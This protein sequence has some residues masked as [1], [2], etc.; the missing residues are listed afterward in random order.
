MSPEKS[1]SLFTLFPLGEGATDEA[2]TWVQYK[3]YSHDMQDNE[4]E[5]LKNSNPELFLY[6]QKLGFLRGI[7]QFDNDPKTQRAYWNG[8]FYVLQALRVQYDYLFKE[9]PAPS[10]DSMKT[11]FFNNLDFE[12]NHGAVISFAPDILEQETFEKTI[13]S[14]LDGYGNT[15]FDVVCKFFAISSQQRVHEVFYENP[16]LEKMLT[17]TSLNQTHGPALGLVYGAFD[18]YDLF[19]LHEQ[20]KGMEE[21]WEVPVK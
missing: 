21:M 8:A 15:T 2:R 6:L 7:V 18:M 10:Q 12:N 1:A 17:R 11:H 4:I 13:N 5:K 16:L 3:L 14:F 20:A 9:I 19:R